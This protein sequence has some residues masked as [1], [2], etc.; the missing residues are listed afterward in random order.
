MSVFWIYKPVFLYLN[1]TLTKNVWAKPIGMYYK[2]L[3][4]QTD[5][6]YLT[7]LSWCVCQCKPL[8]TSLVF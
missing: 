5:N 3:L 1:F 8:K 7:V 6:L 2:I 4:Y